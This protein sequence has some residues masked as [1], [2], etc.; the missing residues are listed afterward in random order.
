MGQELEKQGQ[1]NRQY[2]IWGQKEH[3]EIIK[4]HAAVQ[5]CPF[6][7]SLALCLN[8]FCCHNTTNMELLKHFSH[9]QFSLNLA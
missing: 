4:P 3:A 6:L 7:W 2:F 9:L 8:L 5:V 1:D